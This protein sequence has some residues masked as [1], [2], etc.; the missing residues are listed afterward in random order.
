MDICRFREV[1]FIKFCIN[2]KKLKSNIM[3]NKKSK[4]SKANSWQNV[5]IKGHVISEEGVGLEGLLGLEVMENYDDL[6]VH[7]RKV[8]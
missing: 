2:M 8:I 1:Y 7:N 5:K 6:V 3:V 4:K